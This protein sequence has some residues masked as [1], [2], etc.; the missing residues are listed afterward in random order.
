MVRIL[1]HITPTPNSPEGFTHP[2]TVQLDQNDNYQNPQPALTA[3]PNA[4]IQAALAAIS[5]APVQFIH[6]H[7]TTEA[8]AGGVTNIPFE[9]KK[10][11][12]TA[13]HAD[14]WLIDNGSGYTYLLYTQTMDM[15][16]TIGGITYS[17]PHVTSNALTREG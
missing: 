15:Q 17:F 14:Y 3:N 13:Y 7:V 12:V 16:I 9:D 11:K 4:Q 8:D 6:L 5:P 1:G 10:A 2:Y